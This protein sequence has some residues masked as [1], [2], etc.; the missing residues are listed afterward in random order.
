MP[1]LAWCPSARLR[2]SRVSPLAKVCHRA[3]CSAV[4]R[5]Q[6]GGGSQRV[7]G[8]SGEVPRNV[9]VGGFRADVLALIMGSVNRPVAWA[10]ANA[11]RT[12]LSTPLEENRA[13]GH[14]L[15]LQEKCPSLG[16]LGSA[17]PAK[18]L[19]GV[20]LKRCSGQHEGDVAPSSGSRTLLLE[21]RPRVFTS[22]NANLRRWLL[23]APRLGT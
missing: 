14:Q 12:N 3:G 23:P 2:R 21:G 15:L 4:R 18:C 10:H 13:R 19:T 6:A 9:W 5:A 11:K 8:I 17:E 1:S 20:C 7:D 16:D 22:T